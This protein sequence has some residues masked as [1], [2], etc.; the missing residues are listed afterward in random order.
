MVLRTVYL[1]QMKVL[2]CILAVLSLQISLSQTHKF[3]WLAGTWKMPGKATYEVWELAGNG[4]LRGTSFRIRSGDTLVTEVIRLAY[5]DGSY[6]YIPDVAGDQ[7]PI[8]FLITSAD[9]QSFVAENTHHD[10]PKIIRYR[11]VT[12]GGREMIE[13]SIEGNGKVIP[14]AFEKIE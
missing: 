10:F 12:K 1:T 2:F 9:H 13:A 7:P 3:Q 4:D 8:D 6:H 11:L 14:Y 5:S